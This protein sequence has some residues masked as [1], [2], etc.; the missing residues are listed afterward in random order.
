MLSML[1]FLNV[2]ISQQAVEKLLLVDVEHS[3]QSPTANF[4]GSV[5][6]TSIHRASRASQGSASS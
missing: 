5:F 2:G 4:F 3:A 1:R 6:L